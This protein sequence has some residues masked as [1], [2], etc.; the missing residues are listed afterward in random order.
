MQW[1]ASQA[2]LDRLVSTLSS[3]DQIAIDTEADSLHSYFDKVCLVQITAGGDDALLDPLAG[4]EL[5]RLSEVL[6]NPAQRKI[7]H[8]ADYDLRILDRDFGLRIVNL[9]DTMVAAQLLGLESFGLAALLNRYFGVEVDKK[10]QRADWA[11]RPLPEDM[12]RYAAMD[13]HYLIE[14]AS[15]LESELR[16][17]GRWSWAEEEFARLEEIRWKEPE[18]VVEGFRK[19]KKIGRLSRRSLAVLDRLWNWRDAQARAADKPPF[20]IMQ[21]ETMISI[22]ETMPSSSSELASIRGFSPW[23][24]RRCT[25]DVLAMIEEARGLAES[26]LPER[27][28]IK[29]WN[30]DRELERAVESL[31]SI[32]DDVAGQL[33]I[34]S[35]VL[36]PRH[37]LTAI[38][39]M[40]PQAPEDLDAVPALRRW[41]RELLGERFL[42]ALSGGRR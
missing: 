39:T 23:H 31:R 15:R 1:I 19:L 42:Q 34:E 35:S 7:L 10:H 3:V 33:S 11:M 37:V 25:R 41:Q 9:F 17:K 36:A 18:P 13:T 28:E 12:L 4:I 27:V 6:A 21:N 20:R 16:E 30:R 22:A 14:L 29:T 32:R 40:R 8:G 2:E 26:E 5:K 24:Q 38:A